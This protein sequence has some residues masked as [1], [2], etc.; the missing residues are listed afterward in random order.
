M[1]K[2]HILPYIL[3]YGESTLGTNVC[4]LYCFSYCN[5]TEN[6]YIKIAILL[7]LK[8][9]I[10]KC[11]PDN[12]HSWPKMGD[13]RKGISDCSP[14]MWASEPQGRGIPAIWQSWDWSHSSHSLW[15]TLRKH[16]MQDYRPQKAEVTTKEIIWVSSDSCIFPYIEKC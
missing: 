7:F 8:K 3:Y 10:M 12:S 4:Q 2:A 16:R 6:L 11:L 1:R 15:W 5:T 13:L 14:S 9:L